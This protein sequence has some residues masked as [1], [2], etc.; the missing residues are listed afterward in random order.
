MSSFWGEIAED[1]HREATEPPA[2]DA[3]WAAVPVRWQGA[4]CVLLH[5]QTVLTPED[6]HERQPFV[7]EG[8]RKV[9]VLDGR[10]DNRE[11][12]LR[13]LG[14]PRREDPLPDSALLA[15]ALERWGSEACRFLIGD[16]AFACW[17]A[18]RR[19]LLLACDQTGGRTAFY[20]HRDGRIVFSTALQ[21]LRAHPS[22]SPEVDRATLGR[23]LADL[24][25]E[26]SRTTF[27]DIRQLPPGGQLIWEGGR[28][29]LERYWRPDWT[30]RAPALR[31]ET[32]VEEARELLD[33]A[34]AP[35][36]RSLVPVASMLSGGLDSSA[37]T[38]TAAR[39][40]AP[41]CID[42]FTAV[43]S[44]GSPLP[45]ANAWQFMDEGSHAVSVARMHPG[46][47]HHLCAPDR[48]VM[49]R[50]DETHVFRLLGHPVRNVWNLAWFETLYSRVRE[51]GATVLLNGEA[52]NMTLSFS[53]NGMLWERL[54]RA[55]FLGF[56]REA[57]F[58][59]AHGTSLRSLLGELLGPRRVERLKQLHARIL[60]RSDPRLARSAV[61]P[62]LLAELD[63]AGGTE[64]PG[65]AQWV[66]GAAGPHPRLSFEIGFERTLLG[67][68]RSSPM[69]DFHGFES[70][71]PFRDIR[72]IEFC[73]A[74]PPEQFIRGG[75]RR[76]FA[77]RVL[78]DRLPPELLA[79]TRKGL[80]GPEWF[81]VLTRNRAQIMDDLGRMERS[82]LAARVLDLARMRAV[83]EAWPADVDAAE[84]RRLS[85]ILLNRG[86]HMGR[87]LCW[88]EGGGV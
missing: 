29:R 63:A 16:F 22:V 53:S 37:V 8:G 72:L 35:R 75:V 14:P 10:L 23:L 62:D 69:A 61:H 81:H 50:M 2:G 17:D 76:A 87:F 5:R 70:R 34:V 18:G 77:R 12:L 38:A 6:R 36:L 48:E 45:R 55:E 51:R 78:A 27:R 49:E 46:I 66:A 26:P 56:T 65:A 52:G 47:I 68:S 71:D 67:Y 88:V 25:P 80:Q 43:P 73:L 1:P 15:T 19:S 33:R 20:H 32:Y 58:L 74:L 3:A 60:G 84:L 57:A 11:D 41:A 28:L 30:R 64:D 83:A 44:A 39:L 9:L 59:L 7:F 42:A 40:I 13:V 79:E 85:F 82:P 86:I 4:G 24:G 21:A 54:G 31:D